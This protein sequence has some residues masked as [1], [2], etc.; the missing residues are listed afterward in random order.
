MDFKIKKLTEKMELSEPTTIEIIEKEEEKLEIK[1]PEQ[2][3]KFMLYSDG[4]EGTV[5]DNAYLVIWPIDQIALLNEEYA[6][7][8]FT[9]GLVYFGSDGGGMAYAFDFREKQEASIVQFPFESISIKDVELCGSD[10]MQFLE[11][12]YKLD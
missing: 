10:F 11:Y 1:L 2:Y 3:K 7:N 5:G 9:P 8:E 4:A 6:V 12:L